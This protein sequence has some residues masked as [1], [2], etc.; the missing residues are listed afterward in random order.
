MVSC[1]INISIKRFVNFSSCVP[2]SWLR[3]PA[4]SCSISSLELLDKL[5]MISLNLASFEMSL[6]SSKFVNSS[7]SAADLKLLWLSKSFDVTLSKLG[8]NSESLLV[9]ALAPSENETSG[10][11]SLN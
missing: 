10:K 1:S 4:K 11:S 8:K 2:G 5:L 9:C 3:V 6:V 7:S